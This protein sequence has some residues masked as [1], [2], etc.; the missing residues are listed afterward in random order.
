[1]LMRRYKRY[2]VKTYS[3]RVQ[4]AEAGPTVHQSE[5]AFRIA[6]AIY[7]DLD[8]DSEHFT[9]LAL[10]AQH[11]V[12]G[13]K[14]VAT[15]GMDFAQVDAR[16][17]FRAA[18]LLGATAIIVVHNHPSGHPEPSQE[19]L[20]I[21]SSLVRLGDL[22]NIEVL[23]HLVLGGTNRYVSLRQRGLLRK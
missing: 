23:D 6:V 20:R 5:D 1:M 14:V 16:L 18:L 2:E 9:V 12:I 13:F 7:R 15:G 10:D 3:I 17:V 8:A 4:V 21:T 22:L 19:D 11:H